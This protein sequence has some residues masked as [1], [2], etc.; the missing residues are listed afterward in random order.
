MLLNQ[1]EYILFKI[2]NKSY[3]FDIKNKFYINYLKYCIYIIYY[4]NF[5]KL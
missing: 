5:Q 4:N 1:I 2:S 3:N